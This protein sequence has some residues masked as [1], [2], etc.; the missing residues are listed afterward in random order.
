MKAI[1]TSFSIS[2]T[3]GLT[4]LQ[5][6]VELHAEK[7]HRKENIVILDETGVQ[8]LR[9]QT[10]LVEE[11][12]FE[13]TVFAIGRVEEI[14]ANQYSLSSRIPGRA[15]EINA[16]IGERVKKGQTLVVV[17]SRQPG[18]PPPV[19]SLKAPHEGIVTASHV[20]KGQP[21]EPNQDLLDISD[22]K[23]VWVIA[24]IPEQL[25]AGIKI[26]TKASISFPALGGDPAEGRL[27]RFGVKADRDAGTIDGI[28]Q[29]PNPGEKLQPGMRAEFTITVATRPNVLAVPE[30]SVQGDP[31]NRVVYVK[32]FDIQNAFIKSPVVLGE[33]GGG[34]VEVKSGL[35]P[36]D[37]VVTRGSYPLGF[38]GGGNISLKE[39][40]DAAHGHAHNEDGSEIT[41]EQTSDEGDS[42]VGHVHGPPAGGTE[43]GPSNR[44][45]QIY[46]AVT[47]LL[48]LVMAQLLWSAKRKGKYNEVA[49]LDG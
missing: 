12:T 22:R 46:A 11:R 24:R 6:G 38:V 33:K 20:L 32:D 7:S 35:F 19:V 10:V 15:I 30:D 43:G 28:F 26:D 41:A 17:E 18:D 29:I 27:F 23:E 42:H 37:E 49:K 13:R 44:F 25:A 36:G 8:N 45:L 16:F 40:L 3:F 31:A 1:S 14:P 48:L 2:L 4:L 21:V 5:L 9:I 34:W 39:A 47:S